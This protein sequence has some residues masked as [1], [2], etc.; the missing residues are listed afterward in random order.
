[1]LRHRRF[2]LLVCLLV[3][4][5]SAQETRID[6]AGIKGRLLLVG[7]QGAKAAAESFLHGGKEHLILVGA[8]K[9]LTADLEAAAG[10]KKTSLEKVATDDTAMLIERLKSASAAWFADDALSTV[11]S[12]ADLARA[13]R[14]VLARGGTVAASGKGVTAA[15]RWLPGADAPALDLLP[16]CVVGTAK[17][18]PGAVSI[19]IPEEAALYIEGRHVSALG[20][21]PVTLRLAASKLRP[22]RTILLKGG[23]DLTGLRR[24]ARERSRETKAELPIPEVDKGTLIIIGG[25]GNPK[26]LL[27]R[28]VQLAG[29]PKASIVVLPT[30]ND[31]VPKKEG[32]ADTLRKFGAKEVTVLAGRTLA[33]VESPESLAAFKKASGVWFGGGRQW[34]FVDAYEGTKTQAL[35]KETLARGGVIGGSSAGATIQGDY[36]CRGSPLENFSI[37]Y[38]GYERGFAFLPGVAI[39]QHFSQRKRFADMTGLMKTRPEFLGIGIDET[40][41]IVVQGHIAEV[42]GK[43]K[44][45]FYDP[46]RTREDGKADYEALSAGERYDL[47]LRRVSK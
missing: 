45:H 23:E 17:A 14:D 31:P 24:A 30:A 16:D 5:L 41:A 34:R 27:E 26:G 25:G 13:T 35:M 43:G 36:L 32:I 42:T 28:F 8:D 22:E 29:G 46:T 4:P 21:G 33:Q 39:D 1:V 3:S 9:E 20:R 10:D 2:T 6:P 7:A 15:G 12:R 47:K 18:R 40:T 37:S 38:E 19:G 44:A 11:L